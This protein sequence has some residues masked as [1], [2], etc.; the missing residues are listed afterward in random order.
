[1]KPKYTTWET[2]DPEAPE[3]FEVNK[4]PSLTVPGMALSLDEI[5]QKFATNQ[6]LTIG[7]NPIYEENPNIDEPDL[8]RKP[9]IDITDIETEVSTL[10]KKLQKQAIAVKKA[11]EEAK[12]APTGTKG[13]ATKE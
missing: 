3:N 1:M 11:K 2:F 10:T 13:G 8:L 5:M 7:K 4:E 12:E 6:P 9:G